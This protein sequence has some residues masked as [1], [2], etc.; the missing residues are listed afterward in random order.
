MKNRLLRALGTAMMLFF[1]LIGYPNKL[2]YTQSPDLEAQ[3]AFDEGTGTTAKDS[4]GN[5]RNGA[6]TKA[7]WTTGKIGGA[8]N[9]NGTNNYVSVQPLNYDEISVSAWFY[10]NS[11]DTAAPDTIFGGWSWS[12]KEGYGLYFNQYGGSRNTIQFILHTQTS[13][14]VKTQKYV[15]KDLIASTGKWYHVAGTYDKTTGKQRLYVNGQ[16]VAT[17][18]HPA[19]NTIVPYTERSDMAIGALT[20][21]YGHMDG[22]IDEVRAYKRALSAEE[23]LSLFNNATTQDTT[24]PTVSA[25]SPA[26][27]ATGV[28]GDS[29]IT[30][31]F[32]ETM[33]ASSITTATFLV[34]DGS[35]NIGGVVSYS[36]T[37]ATFT[38][39]GNLPD[40]T[41]YTA[42]IAMGGRDAAGNG[43]TA[44]YIWSFT[45]GAAPDATL[46]SYYTLNEGTG[47]IAT[48]SSG[49]NKNGTITKATWTRGKFGGALSFNG[50]SGTSNFVSIP[51]LNYD[52]ISVSAWFYRYSVDTTAPDTIFGGWS[53]G[54]LQGYGLYFNQYSGSR[55][56]IRF[57]VTTKTSGGIKTQKNAAKDLIASTGKWYHVAGT[58]DKTTGK[59]KLY[60][61]GLLVNTQT[62]P[63]GNIIV[64]YTGASYMA[65]GALTSNYGHMDGNV[66]EVLVYN[67]ALS[68]EDVLAL[69][70]YNSTT[71]DTTPLVRITTPD[72]YYLQENLDLSV[73][74]ETNNLQQNQGI[75]FVADSGTANEQTISD[76]TTPYEVVF[77]N[78]SQ[79]EHV[80]D[81]F[82][83]DEWGNKVSGV[84]THDR[85][86]QVGIGDY[87]VAMGDSITRGDGDDNLSDNTSQD[88]RNAGGGYTPILNNLLTAARGYPHTVFNEGVGG[89]KSSDGASSINKILQKHPNASW[90]LLQY[91]TNDAN[92]FSPVPSGLG[93]N[94]GDSGYSGSFKDNMQKIIDAI[95]NSGKKACVAKAP[96]AL[97][98]GTVSG[99][100]LY[101]DQESK[102]YLI[103]EYNQVI[104]ELVNYP[105]NNIVITPTDFYSYFNYQDPVTGR[106]RYEEEYADFLHPNGVGYQSM[107][108]LWFTALT[109]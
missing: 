6:I 101:P 37:T 109:Q 85:K 87:Y 52:E 28:A 17:Q 42:T 15:T 25:T 90:Y 103:K 40:S 96:I 56:T 31:T 70:F 16:H 106:H 46:Q 14:R 49:N 94:S 98:D 81:A 63:T 53:W 108:N 102:N 105:Q 73:Q 74:T 41:T 45:T 57:I 97:R 77:T 107:A 3:Y 91:G 68:A 7:T 27:N 82:V 13:A 22:K 100:Y 33:D 54:N 88:G 92:Q 10:R 93:L 48:D 51:T 78:L 66:D 29:V 62:H 35:G 50:I 99:H 19:G 86:I 65:I 20:S 26:S 32:S 95:N 79:S 21:N 43:M 24:P 104:D 58:Y 4:S 18:T 71:P 64:P 61:D 84:Y 76:Y 11:V 75:L 2:A 38:P 60:V 80:I 8:L 83:V 9:F 5:N 36:G 44:D 72:N 47:T 67:R 12:K 59:Q 55:D 34:S 39:S 1:L 69:R 30:T 89:T 23:V